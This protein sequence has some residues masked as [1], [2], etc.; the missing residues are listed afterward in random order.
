MK[1]ERP[2]E[3]PS[4]D[5][6]P[7]LIKACK[8]RFL[9]DARLRALLGGG[10]IYELHKEKIPTGPAAYFF[11]HTSRDWSSATLDGQVIE[12]HIQVQHE[13]YETRKQIVSRI[14]DLLHDYTP[15]MESHSVVQGQLLW[16]QATRL[17]GQAHS[18]FEFLTQ[19][20]AGTLPNKAFAKKAGTKPPALACG[21][22]Q[23]GC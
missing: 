23:G 6:A 11:D 19:R 14:A 2:E 20:K 4:R 8:A 15:E 16:Y 10:F 3:I 13:S 9:K 22:G 7:Q 17:P 12:V 18:V 1:T 5:A 21:R